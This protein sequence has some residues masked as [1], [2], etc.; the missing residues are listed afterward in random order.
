MNW[1]KYRMYKLTSMCVIWINA[2]NLFFNGNYLMC[3]I[4]SRERVCSFVSLLLCYL[5]KIAI[6]NCGENDDS[7]SFLFADSFAQKMHAG[8]VPALAL[9]FSSF[10][11][12]IL[13]CYLFIIT[14]N[15]IPSLFLCS[16][17]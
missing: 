8:V 3:S 1:H 10:Y 16:A 15:N 7:D 13:F 6:Q 9:I 11:L 4:V 5:C 17:V 2:M 12:I 14:F